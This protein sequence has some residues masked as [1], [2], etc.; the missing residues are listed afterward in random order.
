MQ[1][2]I[3]AE[4]REKRAEAEVNVLVPKP[5]V[6]DVPVPKLTNAGAEAT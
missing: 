1:N 3:Y 2:V 5:K 6:E 4:R